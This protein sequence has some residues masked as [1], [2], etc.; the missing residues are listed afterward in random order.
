MRT[1]NVAKGQYVTA[2][3]ALFEI[4]NLTTVWVRVP[5]YVGQQSEFV[6]DADAQIIGLEGDRAEE[7]LL[8]RAV[9]A[10]PSA[11]PL[12]ATAD[13]YYELDNTSGN[14]RPGERVGVSL[15]VKGEAESLTVPDAAILY[16][17]HG[18]A[19]VYTQLE[20]DR[21]QRA[22]VIVDHVQGETAVLAGGPEVGTQ[23]VVDGAAELFGTEFGTGK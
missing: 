10:P 12:A 11:D 18:G 21:F 9:A 5:V 20:G 22:R 16:D 13:L 8:A 17:I 1:F 6:A 19:W 15:L 14:F 4:V 3:T 23:V 2:G 7:Q